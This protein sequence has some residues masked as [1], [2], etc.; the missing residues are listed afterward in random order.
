MF[1][2]Y[3]SKEI[4]FS[5]Y[6][7]LSSQHQ[8]SIDLPMCARSCLPPPDMPRNVRI[9]GRKQLGLQPATYVWA[10]IRELAGYQSAAFMENKPCFGGTRKSQNH[11]LVTL[12]L[13]ITRQLKRYISTHSKWGDG[14]KFLRRSSH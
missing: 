3:Q 9:E 2:L 5:Y 13:Y 14:P 6:D 1:I 11:H 4:L 12:P 10:I 8:R 7:S